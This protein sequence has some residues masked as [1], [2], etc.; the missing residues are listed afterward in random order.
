MTRDEALVWIAEL[1]EEP[2]EGISVSSPRDEIA[3][4]DSLGVLTLMAGLDENFDI[5][6]NEDEIGD[7]NSVRDILS[8]LER[9]NALTD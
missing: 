9:H 2:P 4:W 5:Q 7:L 8:V 6:L 3:A 1:F